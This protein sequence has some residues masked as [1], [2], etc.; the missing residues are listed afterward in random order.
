MMRLMDS[1]FMTFYV[2]LIRQ[3]NAWRHTL[4]LLEGSR[5]T[6]AHFNLV[7]FHRFPLSSRRDDRLEILIYC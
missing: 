5:Q 1:Q 6:R 3:I 4:A 7:P 2:S